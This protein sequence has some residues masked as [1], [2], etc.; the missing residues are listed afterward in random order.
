MTRD[1]IKILN[2]NIDT[3]FR[4]NQMVAEIDAALQWVETVNQS[5]FIDFLLDNYDEELEY[6]INTVTGKTD[7]ARARLEDEKRKKLF[8]I[9]IRQF[10]K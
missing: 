6:V 1:S 5:A 3:L 7:A 9:P 10:R 2:H 4:T 8:L